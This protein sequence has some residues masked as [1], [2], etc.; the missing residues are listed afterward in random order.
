MSSSSPRSPRVD[1]SL[2]LPKAVT[3]SRDSDVW[4]PPS[5]LR[6]KGDLLADL[7][8]F[9]KVT[10][11]IRGF[12]LQDLSLSASVVLSL[13]SH[14]TTLSEL[15]ISNCGELGIS[16]LSPL[17]IC[18]V[19]SRSLRVLDLTLSSRQ[20]I[21]GLFTTVAACCPSLVELHVSR[22]RESGSGVGSNEIEDRSFYEDDGEEDRVGEYDIWSTSMSA[23]KSM[24]AR[25]PHL[26][27]LGLEGMRFEE[28]S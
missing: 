22:G 2:A 11:A 23:I 9:A 8:K 21:D 28:V 5:T 17:L 1:K 19:G 20:S 10:K 15:R 27:I 24:L 6:E 13:A 12:D 7:A 26:S 18:N 16:A 3:L 14:A 4:R 25:C